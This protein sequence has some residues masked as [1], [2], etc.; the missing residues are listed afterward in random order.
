MIEFL[1]RISYQNFATNIKVNSRLLSKL[2]N[3]F[4]FSSCRGNEFQDT[5]IIVDPESVIGAGQNTMIYVIVNEPGENSAVSKNIV[6]D[7]LRETLQEDNR[8]AITNLQLEIVNASTISDP[9]RENV[10]RVRLHNTQANEV[11]MTLIAKHRFL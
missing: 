10:L 6:E 3:F 8:T 2:N 7:A 5:D 1:F 11:S 4:N 9:E